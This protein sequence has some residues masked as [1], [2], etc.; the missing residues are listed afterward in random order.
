VNIEK[1]KK[2]ILLSQK[3]PL[4]LILNIAGFGFI[5]FGL[6]FHNIIWIILGLILPIIGTFYSLSHKIKHKR[7]WYDMLIKLYLSKVQIPFHFAEYSILIIGLWT[8]NINLILFALIL[9]LIGYI[10][11]YFKEERNL[12]I[13]FY[14]TVPKS[15]D[16]IIQKSIKKRY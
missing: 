7:N 6:W 2:K 1:L 5:A 16:K 11:A 15:K 9:K 14:F 10:V 12:G 13:L 3:N 8:R 4:N